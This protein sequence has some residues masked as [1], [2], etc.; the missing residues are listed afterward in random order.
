[1]S[2]Q[3]D[4]LK[5]GWV[6]REDFEKAYEAELGSANMELLYLLTD[7]IDKRYERVLLLRK[8]TCVRTL[9]W[10]LLKRVYNK[11]KVCL[12]AMRMNWKE[13]KR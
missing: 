10:M 4:P 12:A 2:E 8:A 1:M 3:L 13:S 5:L 6:K 9:G 11:A 7:M